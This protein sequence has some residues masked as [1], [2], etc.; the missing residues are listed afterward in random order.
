MGDSE[1]DRA[2]DIEA[3]V[4][5]VD[6]ILRRYTL[7]SATV[8]CEEGAHLDIHYGPDPAHRL[9]IFA[10]S[11]SDSPALLFFHGGYW[12]GG[13]KESRRFPAPAWISRGVTWVPI[14]YRL[15]PEIGIDDIVEDSR[16]AVAWFYEHAE[17]YG[18]DPDA[19]HLAGNSAGG[20]IVGRG[21]R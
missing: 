3:S 14:E 18:C 8:T 11:E 7:S 19:I 16:R 4:L 1:L 13:T 21:R 17:N 9:D 12:K 6:S 5:D 2:Y 20:H 15:A 10:S